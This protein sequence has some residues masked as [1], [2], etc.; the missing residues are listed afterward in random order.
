MERSERWGEGSKDDPANIQF[1]CNPGWIPY[2]S[3]ACTE[4]SWDMAHSGDRAVSSTTFTLESS[5]QRARSHT[6][7][8]QLTES[9]PTLERLRY[10]ATRGKL[11]PLASLRRINGQWR[12]Q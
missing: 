1:W 10:S 7:T 12:G 11:V 5:P 3:I 4:K 8:E 9:G 6:S 2:D